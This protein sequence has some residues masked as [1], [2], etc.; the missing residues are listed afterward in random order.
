MAGPPSDPGAVLRLLLERKRRLDVADHVHKRAAATV[1]AEGVPGMD[2]TRLF[3]DWQ[4][5][6]LADRERATFTGAAADPGKAYLGYVA[7]R[8]ADPYHV[9]FRAVNALAKQAGEEEA[10]TFVHVRWNQE[11]AWARR[12]RSAADDRVA[13]LAQLFLRSAAKEPGKAFAELAGAWSTAI[14]DIRF[15]T[16]PEH[17]LSEGA[18]RALPDEVA[19]RPAF[20][21][22]YAIKHGANLDRMNEA[23]LSV[24]AAQARASEETERRGE[25]S[26]ASVAAARRSPLSRMLGV[27]DAAAETR[28]SSDVLVLDEARFLV[29]VARGRLPKVVR[30]LPYAEFI[31]WLRSNPPG[32][33]PEPVAIGDEAHH[34]M[35]R[36]LSTPIY[37]LNKLPE[38]Y[39]GV[40]CLDVDNFRDWANPIATGKAPV[41]RDPVADYGLHLVRRVYRRP[42]A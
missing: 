32:P 35:A 23:Q 14:E 5:D 16:A 38:D 42:G 1:K 11:M 31:A 6:V 13:V 9:S 15:A 33:E 37:W 17:H 36:I 3:Q 29:E 30:G 4:N 19:Y 22:L 18:I 12:L 27:L 26:A 40:G 2:E 20:L 21:R 24:A 34:A 10:N 25:L 39:E 28:R 8:V 41:P 7:E